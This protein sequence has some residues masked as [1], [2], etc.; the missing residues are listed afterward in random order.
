MDPSTHTEHDQ[1]PEK[2]ASHCSRRARISSPVEVE[3]WALQLAKVARRLMCLWCERGYRGCKIVPMSDIGWGIKNN[4][5]PTPKSVSAPDNIYLESSHISGT[6][7]EIV[8]VCKSA[9][10]VLRLVSLTDPQ[11]CFYF[12]PEYIHCCLTW[13][14][15]SNIP[16]RK[17]SVYLIITNN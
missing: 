16:T 13:L 15:P 9:F 7:D 11:I 3:Q 4:I 1:A 6:I 14:W 8:F 10:Q 12:G 2:E 5:S 17:K